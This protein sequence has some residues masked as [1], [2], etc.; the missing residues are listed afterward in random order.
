VLLSKCISVHILGPVESRIEAIETKET[1]IQSSA[2][3]ACHLA[4][5]PASALL[6][7]V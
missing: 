2:S 5:A 6:D 7:T 4:S 3:S 1:T